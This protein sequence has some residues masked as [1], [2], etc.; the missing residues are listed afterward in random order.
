M[1]KDGR[2]A[3]FKV[4][5]KLLRIRADEVER[6][7]CQSLNCPTPSNDLGTDLPSSGRNRADDTDMRLA[8]LA[9]HLPKPQPASSGRGDASATG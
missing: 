9:E 3:A 8:R 7:E 1:I 2:L 5:G 4:G 6:F